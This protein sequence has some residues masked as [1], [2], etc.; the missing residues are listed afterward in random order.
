MILKKTDYKELEKFISNSR[1]KSYEQIIKKKKLENLVAGYLW[2]KQV[3]ASLYPI[4][5]CLVSLR[6]PSSTSTF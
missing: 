1:L 5:Q 3:S 6:Q 4:L 2:N